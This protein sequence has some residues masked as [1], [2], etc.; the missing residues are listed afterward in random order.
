MTDDMQGL[1]DKAKEANDQYNRLLLGTRIEQSD[2]ALKLLTKGEGLGKDSKGLHE[3]KLKIEQDYNEKMKSLQSS[4]QTGLQ[5]ARNIEG[6]TREKALENARKYRNEMLTEESKYMTE[7]SAV[8]A[9]IVEQSNIF[10]DEMDST[11]RDSANYLT[12]EL[13]PELEKSIQ[14]FTNSLDFSEFSDEN[15]LEAVRRL[16]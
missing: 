3:Q 13:T 14:K 10:R 16:F 6:K 7:Y 12:T 2:N 1:I 15:D 11:W 9:R 8:Q 5:N 4:Y